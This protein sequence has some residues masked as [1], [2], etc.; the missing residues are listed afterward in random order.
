[1]VTVKMAMKTS[2]I[3]KQKRQQTHTHQILILKINY[4]EI[5]GI[6]VKL[7]YQYQ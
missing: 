5:F 2:K 4:C 6:S 1:M 3:K 7:L